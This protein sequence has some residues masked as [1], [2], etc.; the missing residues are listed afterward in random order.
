MLKIN[1]KKSK[2]NIILLIILIL[3]IAV[4]AVSFAYFIVRQ[5]QPAITDLNVGSEQAERLIFAPGDG[6][7][8][9]ATM[10]NFAESNGTLSDTTTSTATLSSSTSLGTSS[11][12][13][14][15]YF[16][17]SDNDFIY[18]HDE[19][20]P[21]LILKV[22]DPTGAVVENIEGLTEKTIVDKDG[23]TITGFDVTTFKGLA[24]V[25]LNHPITN[26]DPT[27]PTIQEWVIEVVFVNLNTNQVENMNKNFNSE[28][29]IQKEEYLLPLGV[30]V[31]EDNGGNTAIELKGNPD[32]TQSVTIDDGVY[33]AADSLGTSYYYRGA[34]DNNWV[35]FAGYYWRIIRVN[36]DG[37]VRMIYSGN[38]APNSSQSIVMTGSGTSIGTGSYNTSS[39]SAEYAGYM[40][41]MS[42]ANG[43]GTNSSA[44]TAIDT[45][46]QNNILNT[47]AHTKIDDSI[48]CNDRSAYSDTGGTVLTPAVG[49]SNLYFGSY[50]R[51]VENKQPTLSCPTRLDAFTVDDEINGNGALT[52]PV[53]LITTDELTMAGMI[54]YTDN[55]NVYLYTNTNYWTM[56][57]Y[58]Y[59]SG[60]RMMSPSVE[61]G[62]SHTNVDHS[63]DIG[64]RPV[65]S[66]KSDVTSTGTGTYDDPYV[67][68]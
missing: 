15:V 66:I 39:D 58:Y 1:F 42:E 14:N 6:I 31:I 48:Y 8:I 27:N 38:T 19:N 5:A 64:Y 68:S 36:G 28:F 11:E 22:T 21:E 49:T 65:I 67:I 50:I 44:K 34:V 16:Y 41:T 9:Y 62:V 59:S 43:L 54:D 26:D 25:K 23:N 29:I 24:T 10:A 51:T 13:Y 18:T 20:T 56:S 17:V 53:G 63:V 60:L 47:D 2:K 35:E 30:N 40:Y 4:I 61:N 3:S 57:T 45:W 52:Y 33:S 7:N 55:K 46:Y 32:F 12:T 37:S